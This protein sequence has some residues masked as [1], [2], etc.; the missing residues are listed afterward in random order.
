MKATIHLTK[1]IYFVT[2]IKDLKVIEL[3][4]TED[5]LEAQI[6]CINYNRKKTM[7]YNTQQYNKFPKEVTKAFKDLEDGFEIEKNLNKI[8]YSVLNI[9]LDGFFENFIKDSDKETVLNDFWETFP[10][11][12]SMTPTINDILWNEEEI[13][14]WKENLLL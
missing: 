1:G 3:L 14:D 4:E 8:G 10:K 9:G 5:E 7:I 11:Y 6:F 2:M 12:K 13:F